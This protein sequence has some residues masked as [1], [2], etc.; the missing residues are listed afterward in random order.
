MVISTRD[1]DRS[2][3]PKGGRRISRVTPL[4]L[5]DVAGRT[6]DVLVV[7]A[8]PSGSSCA[9]WLADAGW[10]VLVVDKKT[11]P[12]EKTCG[13]GLTP[14]AVRQLADLGLEAKVAAAGHRYGGLRAVGFGRTME[15]NWP[16]HPKFPSYGYTITRFDL[17]ALVAEH[18][19]GAGATVLF[20]TEATPFEAMPPVR[21]G[22]LSSVSG[23]TLTQSSTGE[24]VNV[25]ARYVVIADGANSRF[26]RSLGAARRRDWPM[27]MALR[28][29]WTSDRHDDPFIE[30]HIDIRDRSGAMV[31]GYGWIFPLGDGRVNVGVGL[32]S[33]DRTWKGV[34]TTRLMDAFTDQVGES[35]GLSASTCLGPATGGKLPMGLSVGPHVGDNV[36]VTGDAAGGINPFNGEG[37]A[38]GYETGRLAAVSV[39]GALRDGGDDAL[40]DYETQLESAY[41]DYYKVARAFVR[42]ISEPRVMQAC[43][44][45]GMRSDWLMSKLLAIMANLM[46]PDDLGAAELAYRA[47]NAVARRVP[48]DLLDQVL[49]AIAANEHHDDGAVETS[50]VAEIVR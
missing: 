5:D 14:R 30:S 47:I 34:N 23:A 18:A 39:G 48:D 20:G 29:Y 16:S 28:G 50:S 6:Y 32:L 4:S 49:S 19:A 8:G 33:T 37:I 17:D 2:D 36:V 13:D 15:L 42:L 24:S 7:G 35:W 45:V 25:R 22:R 21:E 9:Y 40:N 12:R 3:R 11:L 38:Y 43:V 1:L 31:P 41:A 10:D 44:G 27:G 26:G 46:R